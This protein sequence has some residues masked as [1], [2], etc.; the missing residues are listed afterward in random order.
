M[1]HADKRSGFGKPVSLNHRV[2]EPRPELFGCGGE[3][4]AA[5]N[6]R[7]EFPPETPANLSE[8]PPPLQEMFAIGRLVIAPKFLELPA[9]REIAFDLVAQRF[10]QARHR[11]EH[12]DTLVVNRPNHFSGIESVDKNRGPAENLRQEH[13]QQ[14][15][16]DVTQ[17]QKVEK[18]ERVKEPLVA[19]VAIDFSF[20]GFE[21]R[22]KVP[23]SENNAARFCGGSRGEDDF[24]RVAARG[25]SGAESFRGGAR[26]ERAEVF[27]ANYGNG[28]V[29]RRKSPPDHRYS[30][31]RLLRHARC[32]TF[33]RDRIHRNSDHAAKHASEK[34]RDPLAA[35][36]APDEDAVAFHDAAKVKFAG[37]SRRDAEQIRIRP[38]DHAIAAPPSHR[39]L[40][41]GARIGAKVFEKGLAWHYS[42]SVAHSWREWE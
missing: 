28:N 15:A 11:D 9:R 37:E 39:D 36:F 33:V 29:K 31:A 14:L 12:G 40:L 3:R 10:N 17:R 8:A 26:R 24:D 25:R 16:E 38:A 34:R 2:T 30:N 7:P 19:P 1:V 42:M 18:A 6:H 21:V 23:V 4:G 27:K 20:E 41:R 22:E 13:S 5:G 35:I 32:E